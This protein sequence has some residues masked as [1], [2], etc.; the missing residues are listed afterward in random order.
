M[1]NHFF[2]IRFLLVLCS[3]MSF[4]TAQA[5]QLFLNALIYTME[6]QSPKVSA[7]AIQG[8]KILYVGEESGAKALMGP[9]TV[10][11][12]VQGKVIL[13]GF[14]DA[15]NHLVWS[16]TEQED[17]DLA[18]IETLE[19]L[20]KTIQQYAEQNPAAL[21][22]RGSGWSMVSFPENTLTKELLDKILPERPAYFT[23]EDSH[24]V[25]INSKALELSGIHKESPE[26]S[27]G[28]IER[29]TEGEPTGL[30]REDAMDIVQAFLP[31][32]SEVQVDAGLSK[33][34][35]K[36][37]SYGITTI[38]DPAVE[39]W[40]LEGYRRFEQK[41][42]LS[43]RVRAAVPIKADE[44]I[45][46]QIKE[47]LD[48]QTTFQSEQIKVLG[49]KFYIDGVIESKTAF[50]LE[51]YLD[52]SNGK[53][54]FTQENLN[55]FVVALDQS[56]LEL[57]AHVIGDGAVRQMLD[58]IEFMQQ[59]NPPRDRRPQLVHLEV[60]H[61]DDI[62]RFQSLQ[63]I[64]NFQG[65]WAYPDPYITELT[66]PI[67]GPERS[68]WLYPIGAVLQ[69]G[70]RIAGG[71][72]W[73]VS[74]MNPFEAIQTGVTREDWEDP[75][76]TVLTPEHR[77]SVQEMIKAYT[78]EASYACFLEKETGSLSAG[79]LA[80]FIIMDQDPFE[81]EAHQLVNTKILSTFFSGKEVFRH[82]DY[83][84]LV[85]K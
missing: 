30:L 63:V 12:D 39:P 48:I 57:H 7:M 67:I 56:Q 17:L 43:L 53:S 4:L 51:P 84:P 21:W 50:M 77:V 29:N 81:I 27:N 35:Q 14:I 2:C 85:I 38:F 10:V 69:K 80:D 15:H 72:D 34:L 3:F 28:R 9:Q 61:P 8:T 41:N 59:Q 68:K 47:I 25:W 74:S 13:P 71:S 5:D 42:Q 82:S 76:S 83:T 19:E 26:P 20:L 37:A 1:T 60:I 6:T 73:S 78:V 49:A 45:K 65:L 54:S 32:Y 18:S 46:E 79:K 70:G 64:A 66:E 22:I 40:M 55:T 33:A 36:A 11:Y 62:A 44:D 52:G 31:D 16:G 23:S 58:A 24:S 75:K